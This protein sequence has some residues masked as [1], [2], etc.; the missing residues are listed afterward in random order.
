MKNNYGKIGEREQIQVGRF[1]LWIR[2]WKGLR[3]RIWFQGWVSWGGQPCGYLW[4]I[5][6]GGGIAIARI[7]FCGFK[8]QEE[9][10]NGFSISAS[11]SIGVHFWAVSLPN[12]RVFQGPGKVRRWGLLTR[13]HAWGP[14]S[15]VP[16]ASWFSAFAIRNVYLE[17]S[18]VPLVL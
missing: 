4:N 15:L 3:I 6:P 14:T 2:W 13:P 11:T 7:L 12:N 18:G 10:Q 17:H 8:H 16:R 5:V 1:L 9:S